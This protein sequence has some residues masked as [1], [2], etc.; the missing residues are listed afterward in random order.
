M[1]KA[2]EKFEV[3]SV[4]DFGEDIRLV[5]LSAVIGGADES[6]WDHTVEGSIELKIDSPA[7]AN[8]FKPGDKY[9]ITFQ[10]V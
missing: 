2:T 3:D 6:L 8:M 9:L 5:K 1:K 10:K 4:T 7:A